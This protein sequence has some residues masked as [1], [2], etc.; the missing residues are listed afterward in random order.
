MARKVNEDAPSIWTKQGN[1]IFTALVP[2]VSVKDI[3]GE[4]IGNNGFT[5][6]VGLEVEYEIEGYEKPKKV[7]IFGK[8][9]RNDNNEIIGFS[10]KNSVVSF[11]VRVLG[12]DIDVNDDWSLMQS[13]LQKCVGKK[14]HILKYGKGLYTGGEK[15]T[16]DWQYWDRVHKDGKELAI[17]FLDSISRGYPKDYD[18]Y[19]FDKLAK[20]KT[21]DTTFNY[22][23]NAQNSNSSFD[24][25]DPI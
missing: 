1:A 11:L 15:P 17:E 16:I 12:K 9:K 25:E 3:S 19:C 4:T 8:Y 7:F 13:E 23:A 21:D 22:G 20:A 6:E 18:E 14:T 2:I 24:D 10:Y 5:P